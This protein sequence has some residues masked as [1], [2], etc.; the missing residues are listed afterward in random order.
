MSTTK[1]KIA[2][3]E[4]YLTLW[5][6]LCIALGILIGHLA[7]DD[8]SLLSDLEIYHVNFP[9]AILIWL[10]IYPMMLQIDFGSIKGV[11]RAPKGLIWT[12][13][14]NWLIKP[15]TM[16]FFAWIF[17][18]QLYSAYIKSEMA[19]E[20]IAGAIL[21]G[22]AP[23]T[24]MVF[25]WSYLTEGDPNY[26][27]VQVTVNDLIILVAFVPLV[28]FLLGITNLT[29]PYETLVASVVIFVVI[30]LIAGVITNKSL[31][32]KKGEDWFKNEFLPKFKPVSIIALL[33]TLILLFAFQGPNILHNPLIIL[34]IAVPL[35]IQTYFIF[36]LAW[37]G[38]R[39]LKLRHAVCAPASMI[40]AS[41]FFE[42]AVAVA[43]AL[44]GLDSPAALVT[45]VGVLVEVPVMLHLV[46]LANKWKY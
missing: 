2:F 15:F 11:G 40:G 29:V 46:G 33:L 19:G 27:L 45:V 30:P 39:K 38:G 37:F 34:L 6:G 13:V 4:K 8:I 10:M 12:L 43:I 26:T 28:G 44:F 25:V 5:V 24:A 42:L 7:G 35:I 18:D 3:F 31:I 20:Y 32:A 41:N 9:I 1:K 23:C 36:F 14:I 17:F 22:V 21:L 16:A